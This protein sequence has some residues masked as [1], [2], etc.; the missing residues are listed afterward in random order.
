VKPETEENIQCAMFNIQFAIDRRGNK[1]ISQ[2][3]LEKRRAGAYGAPF[4]S[5]I[6][7]PEQ[8]IF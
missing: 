7:G 8:G 4:S 2:T 5:W 1:K 3:V 6:F